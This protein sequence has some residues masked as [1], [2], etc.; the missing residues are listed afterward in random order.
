MHRTF[1]GS[2]IL[3]S[4]GWL[5]SIPTTIPRCLLQPS[6]PCFMPWRLTPCDFIIASLPCPAALGW[7]ALTEVRGWTER[8]ARVSTS[9]HSVPR[10]FWWKDSCSPPQMHF[11]EEA[12]LHGLR[13]LQAL[14]PWYFLLY[15]EARPEDGFWLQTSLL[16]LFLFPTPTSENSSSTSIKFT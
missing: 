15:P 1:T 8:K 13:S 6:L 14:G 4:S 2:K 5:F 10:K 9:L 12:L 3:N 11:P 16:Y 7:K